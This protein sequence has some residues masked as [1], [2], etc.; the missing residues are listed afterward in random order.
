M[1]SVQANGL[2]DLIVYIIY[3]YWMAICTP[4][5][6][7]FSFVTALFFGDYVTSFYNGNDF[8]SG[9]FLDSAKNSI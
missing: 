5:T 4:I 6:G 3:S 9:S 2:G 1:H 7:F 8:C